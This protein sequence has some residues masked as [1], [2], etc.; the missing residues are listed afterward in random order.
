[1]RLLRVSEQ[2]PLTR[3][4][5][6]TLSRRRRE[7]GKR[8]FVVSDEAVASKTSPWLQA[9]QLAFVALYAVTLLVALRWGF[10][11]VRQIDP[12]NTAVVVRLGAIDRVRDAGLL[13]ALPAP[14][15]QVLLLP[16]AESVIEH[17]VT[18]LA[19][20]EAARQAEMSASDDDEAEP[21]SD[22]L[23]GSGYL[24]TGDAG[25]VQM[26]VR[27]FYKVAD[28]R[29]YALQREHVAP[30]LDR[31][32]TR[33]AVAACAA[34]DLDTILV[35]RPELVADGANSVAAEQRERLRGDL[36]QRI[37]AGLVALKS[38]GSGLG[39]EVA[40]VDVQSSLPPATLAAFNA[41]LTASQ[42]AER[43]VAEARN[44]AAW[45]TQQA[46]QAADRMLQVAQAAAS[47]RLAKAQSD[48]ATVQQLAQSMKDKV[49]PGLL[50]RVYRERMKTILS[51]AGSV[52]T[53]DPRDDARLILSGVQ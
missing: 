3:R 4:W 2:R 12:Q 35:A 29:D 19:R 31:L 24:L 15:E 16:S 21:L 34:R 44:D 6:D 49:D 53:V 32:V 5:R 43:N 45:N 14:F 13:W 25:I 1:M 23:A 47:E 42:Q 8:S 46:T 39:I 26:D 41:V 38:A 37:N 48:T 50:A 51:Q 7:R 17:R 33:T 22:A 18:G 40:R 52:T 11:N 27:V 20:S 10:S 30:A 36:V 28:P 9:G